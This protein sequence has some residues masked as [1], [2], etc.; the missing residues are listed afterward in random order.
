MK[1][2]RDGNVRPEQDA[3]QARQRC[4]NVLQSKINPALYSAVQ[5]KTTKDLLTLVHNLPTQD[6]EPPADSS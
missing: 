4:L 6:P 3:E 2:N 1:R 5:H